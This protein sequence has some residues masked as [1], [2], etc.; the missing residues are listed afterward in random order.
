MKLN[1]NLILILAAILFLGSAGIIYSISQDN[2]TYY[3]SVSDLLANPAKYRNQKIRVLGQVVPGT[4]AWDPASLSLKFDISSD[5]IGFLNVK[6][7][8][9]KPDLFKEGQ[10]VVAEGVWEDSLVADQLLVKH[11]PEY[12]APQSA[13][14]IDVKKYLE[15]LN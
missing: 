8:G 6:F 1:R 2:V 4:S 3:I 14:N 15:T 12:K 10:G 9:V 5:N 11:S 13:T 7:V